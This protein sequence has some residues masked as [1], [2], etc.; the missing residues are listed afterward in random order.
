MSI[1]FY[2]RYA[3]D[4]VIILKDKLT[5]RYV[6]SEITNVL[7]AKLNLKINKLKTKI[8]PIMQGVNA[9]GYKSY[10]T[11]RLLRNESKKKIKRKL[12]KIPQLIIESMMTIKKA[13]QMINSWL[14]HAKEAC[15]LNFVKYLVERFGYMNFTIKNDKWKIKIIKEAIYA[16]N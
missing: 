1:K 3:D 7:V 6:L 8:F 13:E 12:K 15:S 10:A 11:H 16:F 9:I 4:I 2:T 14:G 5:A